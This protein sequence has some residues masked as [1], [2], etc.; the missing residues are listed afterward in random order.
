[1][2]D[3]RKRVFVGRVL[4]AIFVSMT[5]LSSLHVHEMSALASAECVECAH[6]VSHAGHLSTASHGID[7][8]VLCQFIGLPMIVC[9]A[10][11]LVLLVRAAKVVQPVR[12]SR[13]CRRSVAV[14]SLRAPPFLF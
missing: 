6:H 5:L 7:S 9:A 10:V 11:T 8:C 13:V 2:T 4:L 1:M 14:L 12:V 3:A